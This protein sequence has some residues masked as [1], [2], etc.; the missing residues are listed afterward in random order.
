MAI[1]LPLPQSSGSFL[2]VQRNAA[3]PLPLQRVA[4]LPRGLVLNDPFVRALAEA[5]WIVT[6]ETPS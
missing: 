2:V 3:T 5:C 4:Q 1:V 6:C